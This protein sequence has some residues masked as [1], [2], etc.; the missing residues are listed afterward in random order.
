MQRLD[1]AAL[2][3]HQSMELAWQK[4]ARWA[5]NACLAIRRKDFLP[6]KA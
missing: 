4:Q 6:A 2:F 3:Y 1:A 5:R